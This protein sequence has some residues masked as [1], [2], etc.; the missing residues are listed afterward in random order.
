MLAPNLVESDLAVI[1]GCP[2]HGAERPPA[3][4]GECSGP[5]RAG[6]AEGAAR[7]QKRAKSGVRCLFRPINMFPLPVRKPT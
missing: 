2:V 1:L 3:K 7:P 5:C 4:R 6:R